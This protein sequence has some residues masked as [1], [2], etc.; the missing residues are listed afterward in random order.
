MIVVLAVLAAVG[1]AC[2]VEP[3]PVGPAFGPAAI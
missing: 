1:L 2:G 3:P